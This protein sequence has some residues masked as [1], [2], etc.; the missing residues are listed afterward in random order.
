MYKETLTMCCSE[1]AG[2]TR[3]QLLVWPRRWQGVCL[4]QCTQMLSKGTMPHAADKGKNILQVSGGQFLPDPKPGDGV[5]T[6]CKPG[7]WVGGVSVPPV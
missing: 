7:T 4:V 6:A 2:E 1:T 5:D 3:A